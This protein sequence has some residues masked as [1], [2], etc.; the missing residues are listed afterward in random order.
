H[1]ALR[2]RLLVLLNSHVGS[3]CPRRAPRAPRSTACIARGRSGCTAQG[4]PASRH[5]NLLGR[6]LLSVARAAYERA[7]VRSR[8]APRLERAAA[9]HDRLAIG[10]RARIR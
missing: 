7:D 3:P 4:G 6:K 9:G 5:P 8:A 1:A 2:R 10:P